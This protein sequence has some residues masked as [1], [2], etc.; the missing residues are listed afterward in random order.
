M[1]ILFDVDGTLDCAGGTVPVDRLRELALA[2]YTIIIVSPS[3]NRPEGFLEI[4]SSGENRRDSLE[5]VK[6]KYPE[7]KL[8]LYISDNPEDDVLARELGFCYIH[9]S[10]F[11]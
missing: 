10:N 2:G 9:P 3:A 11:Y 7:E 8:G 1:L 5:E 4:P 6:R